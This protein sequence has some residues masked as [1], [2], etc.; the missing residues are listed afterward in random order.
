[1]TSMAAN[2]DQ[3]AAWNGPAVDH[4]IS[5]EDRYNAAVAGYQRQ[6]Q[7]VAAVRAGESVLDIGC[8][9]GESAREAAR[10]AAPGVVLGV[11]LSE[12]M[13]ARARQRAAAEGVANVRFECVDAQTHP[14][15]STAFQV[16]ISRFGATFFADPVV[17]FAN[18]RRALAPGGRLVLVNWQELARNEWLVSIRSALA[19]GRALSDPP[20]GAVGP[21][22]L[23]DPQATGDILAAAGFAGIEVTGVCEPVWLGA[24]PADAEAYLHGLGFVRGLL[25]G[26]D[27]AGQA[28]ARD[29]LV[30][31][32]AAHHDAE[33]VR[34]GSAAWLV[35]THRP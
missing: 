35:A 27:P 18:I 24:D 4:W 23:A 1:M 14:F 17:A 3:A 33:G 2:A 29:R 28:R 20:V 26:L 30:A 10:R 6:L 34:Y 25:D 11:D 15:P 31:D 21:F 9:C 8:G 32:L 22:G 12:Q 13:I 5:H 7:A 19:V 16:A